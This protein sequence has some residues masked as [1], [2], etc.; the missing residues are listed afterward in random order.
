MRKLIGVTALAAALVAVTALP[1]LAEDP[2][3]DDFGHGIKP[4]PGEIGLVI[5]DSTEQGGSGGGGVGQGG[6]GGQ[7][8]GGGG[9]GI[10]CPDAGNGVPGQVCTLPSNNLATRGT[11][12]QPLIDPQVIARQLMA[13]KALGEPAIRM[14]PS[15]D[16]N[17]LV[18]PQGDSLASTWLWIDP[19][20]WR[21][22]TLSRSLGAELVSVTAH[23]AS[24]AWRLTD[25]SE[26][27]TVVCDGPGEPYNTSLPPEAQSTNCR[28]DYRHAA[29]RDTVTATINWQ[30]N[31]FATGP[32]EA[33]GSWRQETTGQTTVRVVQA[34]S[35]NSS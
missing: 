30:V 27:A 21:D 31:W 17:Q 24:V 10:G 2:G 26:S 18:N 35:L 5:G 34:Q 11:I 32:V 20:G 33:A 13:V 23:P 29:A 28:Y 15:P 16:A 9:P 8:G 25:G 7:E 12:T 14:S 4:G 3:A 22:I 1:V 19:S 6:G